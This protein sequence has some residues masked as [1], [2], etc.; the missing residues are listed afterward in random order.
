MLGIEQP[1]PDAL[2]ATQKTP[3]LLTSTASEKIKKP[4]KIP[5]F[6]QNGQMVF[7]GG[8]SWIYSTT[9]IVKASFFALH[10]VHQDASYELSKTSF[11]HFSY[12]FLYMGGPFWFK[13]VVNIYQHYK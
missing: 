2:N 5:I 4:H 9:Y 3:Q 6:N 8:I 13:G 7:L 11:I 1:S 12:F 10:S